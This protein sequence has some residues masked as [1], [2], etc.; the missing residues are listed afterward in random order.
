MKAGFWGRRRRAAAK[1]DKPPMT[2]LVCLSCKT[3]NSRPHQE[4][5]HIFKQTGKCP[6]CGG[7]MKITGIYV[8]EPKE[9]KAREPKKK[10]AR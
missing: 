10:K 1:K 2:H 7:G 9:K 4:G 5:D 6:K 3:E 8:E